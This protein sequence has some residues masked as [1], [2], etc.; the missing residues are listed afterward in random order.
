MAIAIYFNLLYTDSKVNKKM[1]M[2]TTQQIK[3]EDKANNLQQSSANENTKTAMDFFGITISKLTTVLGNDYI[4]PNDY[5]D[6]GKYVYYEGRPFTFFISDDGSNLNDSVISNIRIEE[7]GWVTDKLQVGMDFNTLGKIRN[8]D[9]VPET[10]E[11]SGQYCYTF[12]ISNAHHV[13]FYA[14]TIDGPT[15]EAFLGADQ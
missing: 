6:G 5:I 12:Y 13:T 4:F 10:D 2:D 8:I 1:P 3:V 14:D 15:T 7:G 11:M 9:I